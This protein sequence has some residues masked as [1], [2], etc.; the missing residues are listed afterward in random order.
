MLRRAVE[1]AKELDAS[2]H[3]FT[4][5]PGAERQLNDTGGDEFS[6]FLL[7]AARKDMAKLQAEAGTNL[8]TRLSPEGPAS[9][10]SSSAG[11][12]NRIC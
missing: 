12:I 7:D 4:R 2:L 6:L 11:V 5:F 1:L 8:E 10:A 3:W 9:G